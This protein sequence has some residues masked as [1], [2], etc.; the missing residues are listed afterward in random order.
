MD[1]IAFSIGLVGLYYNGQKDAV[2]WLIFIGSS[3]CWLLHWILA[4]PRVADIEFAA[5]VMSLVTIGVNWSNYQKW[6]RESAVSSREGDYPA[7]SQRDP[8]A[9]TSTAHR[10]IRRPSAPNAPQRPAKK[11]QSSENKSFL[12]SVNR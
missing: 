7:P 12:Q 11:Y 4:A 1:W 5:A 6:R 2:C 10:A 3:V 8:L 9:S